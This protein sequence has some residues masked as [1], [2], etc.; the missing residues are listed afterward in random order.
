MIYVDWPAL[1]E[2]NQ[3]KPSVDLAG[4]GWAGLGWADGRDMFD[5]HVITSTPHVSSLRAAT[6]TDTDAHELTHDLLSSSHIKR[7]SAVQWAISS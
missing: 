1:H 4:L 7:M 5:Q 6:Y 2:P 3:I